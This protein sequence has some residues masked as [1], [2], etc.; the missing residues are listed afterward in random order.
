MSK[1]PIFFNTAR[2]TTVAQYTFCDIVVRLKEAFN[3]F[4]GRHYKTPEIR[5]IFF[6]D[7]ALENRFHFYIE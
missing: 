4:N 1:S 5:N 7:T 2:R 6:K 3:E